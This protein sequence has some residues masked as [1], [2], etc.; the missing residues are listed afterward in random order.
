MHRW[1]TATLTGLVC[2]AAAPRPF[3]APAVVAHRAG[4][5]P[6]A[7]RGPATPELDPVR[8]LEQTRD[9]VAA[10]IKGYRAILHKQERIFG[11]LHP[12]EVVAISIR[13]RPY[14]VRLR[15]RSGG[16]SVLGSTVEGLVYSTGANDGRLTVWRPGASLSF[17]RYLDVGPADAA[18]RQAARYS[19]T[20]ASLAHAAERTAR[21]WRRAAD[22]GE[23]SFH[24]YGVR[25]DECVGGRPC[26]VFTRY[27]DPPQVD[28]FLLDEPA[29]DAAERP[30]D[31]AASVTIW[32][33]VSTGLQVG[34][35]L[36]R[37]DGELVG[38]YFFTELELNPGFRA[39]EFSR[40]GLR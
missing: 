14:A 4:Y 24:Y 2:L 21:V 27:S 9:R 23:L 30:G 1:I 6:R 33:D 36:R 17:L 8:F 29:P 34:S 5:A 7:E 22:A 40:E 37:A 15:W 3:P 18:A 38:A 25:R 28:S 20:E 12:P 31:A 16:R 39:G 32:V 35:E 19:A 26:H 10:G 13:A 11:A